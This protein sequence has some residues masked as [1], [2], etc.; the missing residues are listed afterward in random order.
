[1]TYTVWLVDLDLVY[2]H[3]R[4]VNYLGFKI[5]EPIILAN[6]RIYKKNYTIYAICK[7][8]VYASF[9]YYTGN[10]GKDI[11]IHGRLHKRLRAIERRWLDE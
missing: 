8:R 2:V 6:G 3:E 5:V 11:S 10:R 1:M 7:D 9:N 4:K